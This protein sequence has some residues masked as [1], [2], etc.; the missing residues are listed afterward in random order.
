[1]LSLQVLLRICAGTLP[2]LP[3]RRHRT[4]IETVHRGSLVADRACAHRCKAGHA[5]QPSVVGDR[6]LVDHSSEGL[7]AHQTARLDQECVRLLPTINSG[8]PC[9]RWSACFRVWGST[10]KP[11]RQRAV[12]HERPRPTVVYLCEC[13][14]A[15]ESLH[16]VHRCARAINAAQAGLHKINA[17]HA[18]PLQSG[19]SR[20]PL[21]AWKGFLHA[22]LL[23]ETPC[24]YRGSPPGQPGSEGWRSVKSTH[25]SWS[26][27]P[28]SRPG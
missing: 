7:Q 11:Y 16:Q 6:Q 20:L 1:M 27:A 9:D 10:P 5:G 3:L 28:C 4:G 12:Q 26:G 23:P 8:P 24:E 25:Q 21:I 22:P 17:K 13:A 19:N 2:F 15:C 18:A 14:D